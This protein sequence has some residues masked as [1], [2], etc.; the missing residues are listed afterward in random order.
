VTRDGARVYSV[1]LAATGLYL[2]LC[3][4]GRTG[5]LR[6]NAGTRKLRL[7]APAYWKVDI[8]KLIE[9]LAEHGVISRHDA[10]SDEV[11]YLV[12]NG[13]IQLRKLAKTKI[14]SLESLVTSLSKSKSLLDKFCREFPREAEAY[15]LK[16]VLE[17]HTTGGGAGVGAA[18]T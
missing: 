12:R 5:A 13:Y 4:D 7:E 1:E 8:P 17:R 18:T 3:V 16:E 10:Y 11:F 14:K 2:A 9:A 15:I 6:S